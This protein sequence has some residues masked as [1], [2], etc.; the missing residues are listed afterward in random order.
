MIQFRSKP[1]RRLNVELTPLIDIMFQLVLFFI[2]TATFKDTPV[3]EV[4]LPEA[5][6]SLVLA[7]QEGITVQIDS[8]GQIVFLDNAVSMDELKSQLLDAFKDR[9]S[10]QVLIEADRDTKHYVITTLMEMLQKI[11][12]YEIQI[13]TETPESD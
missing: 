5:T 1:N 10:R 13:A 3:F 12:I 7:D 4:S 6:S 11:E 9:K 8:N 2:V